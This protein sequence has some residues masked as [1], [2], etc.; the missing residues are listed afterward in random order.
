[1]QNNLKIALRS[2]RNNKFYSILNLS[3][4]VVGMATT[5][6]IFIAC[7]GLLGLIGYTIEQRTKEI[8]IRKVLGAS[9]TSIVGL[10]AK[11]YLK[12]VLL[13]F[14]IAIPFSWYFMTDWLNDFAYRIELEWWMFG[15][16][17]LV[18]V[19]IAFATIGVQSMKAALVNP[20]ESLKTE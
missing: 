11:D 17:G 2:F 10:L 1:M 6:S 19:L 12:L 9:V 14:F 8:G 13:A 20:V 18:A 3:G 5:L 15:M 4:L 16:A 7:L